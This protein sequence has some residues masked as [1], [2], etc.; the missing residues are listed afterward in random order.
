MTT[1]DY[2]REKIESFEG[3]V[4]KAYKARPAE[5]YWTIG[6]GHY[7]PDVKEGDVI[8]KER[9]DELFKQDLK[10]RENAINGL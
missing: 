5:K 8:T 3:C 4:L 6:Y 7:G 2:G 9:A 10:A 1:S